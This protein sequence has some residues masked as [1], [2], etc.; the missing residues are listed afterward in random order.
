MESDS[1]IYTNLE[2]KEKTCLQRLQMTNNQIYFESEGF[3]FK[4]NSFSRP[5]S[6][7]VTFILFCDLFVFK[8]R[9]EEKDLILKGFHL[10]AAPL[11][12]RASFSKRLLKK[13]FSFDTL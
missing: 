11:H 7:T 1:I 9:M 8:K 4:M 10:S 12:H 13:V 6:W 2:K 3:K 5:F